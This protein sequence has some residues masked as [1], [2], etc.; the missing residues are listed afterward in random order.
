MTKVLHELIQYLETP[1][2]V[3]A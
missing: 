3:Y 2:K 1:I